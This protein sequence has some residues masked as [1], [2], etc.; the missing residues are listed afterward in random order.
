MTVKKAQGLLSKKKRVRF[1]LKQTIKINEKRQRKAFVRQNLY[2]A[3]EYIL[4][5]QGMANK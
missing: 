1:V 3:F 4:I 2:K 5:L